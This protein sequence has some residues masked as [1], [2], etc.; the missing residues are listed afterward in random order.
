MTLYA[1]RHGETEMNVSDSATG[2][3]DAHLTEKGRMQAR[4]LQE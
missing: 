3:F 1:V 4:M 2:W